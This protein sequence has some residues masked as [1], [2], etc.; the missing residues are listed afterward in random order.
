[1]LIDVSK[2]VGIPYRPGGRGPDGVDCYGLIWLF[3]QQEL[4]IALPRYQGE[5]DM[6]EMIEVSRVVHGIEEGSGFWQEIPLGDAMLGDVV[7]LS[8]MGGFH[9]GIYVPRRKMLH[10][11]L[12]TSSVIEDLGRSKWSKRFRGCFRRA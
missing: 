12:K 10:C 4:G 11:M 9:V 6:A 8:V 3:Y 7:D 1:M 5:P 2:Y